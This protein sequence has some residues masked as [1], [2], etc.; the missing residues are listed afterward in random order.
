VKLRAGIVVAGVA[1]AALLTPAFGAGANRAPTLRNAPGTGFPDRD[2]F[3]QFPSKVQLTPGTVSVT[4]NGEPVIGLS[5]EAPGGT[6]SGAILLVDAS[7]SMTGKPIKGAMAAGRAFMVERNADLPVAVVAFNPAINVLADFSTDKHTLAVAVGKAPPLSYETH[8]YDA[9]EKAA[10]MAKH[11]GLERT[12][13]V[14]LSDGQELGSNASYDEA[15]QAVKEANIRVISIGLSSRFYNSSTL[16]RIAAD[17]GGTYIEVKKASQ[18]VPLY[19]SLSSQISNLYVVTYRSLLAPQV[20]ANVKVA[21]K[22]F[23]PATAHYTTPKLNV[24]PSGTFNRT[25]LD[26]VIES[27]YLMVF[28]IVAVLALLAFAIVSALDVRSRSMKRRMAH[29]VNI[30]TEEEGRLRREEVAAM[31]AERAERKFKSY[32]WWQNFERDVEIAGFQASPITMLGWAL[33]AG[34]LTSIVFAIL[35]QSLWGLLVGLVAPGVMR[36][37]VSLRLS[38]KRAEFAEQL[39][40][41]VDVL[42]GA[43][44]AGHSLVG[45]MNVMVDGAAEPSRDE[46]RR[47]MQDEQLGVPIDEALMVMSERMANEDLEQV[48]LVTRLSREAGGNTAEV[49][50]R[51]VDNIR[52]KMELRRLVKVLTAQGRM[53]RWILT[54]L[55]VALAGWI[56]VINPDWLDPLFDTTLGNVSLVLWVVLL[57]VGS[58]ILKKITDIVV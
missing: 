17:T 38:R 21:A 39:P 32:K 43:L 10:Q 54:V 19:S 8:T 11:Q 51:V 56:L 42:A 35:L 40:D 37:V 6:A 3:L 44:R 9:L 27:P 23:P 7:K 57:L 49:L 18:L 5:I 14:L 41:N 1:L 31:L 28:V 15:L 12:T 55:P 48:A 58:F 34:I 13:V 52:G 33:I 20:K 26:K 22:G 16:K 30:P 46:F 29:Y 45:A 36:F 2:Y 53:A 47:V 4:E 24:T 25:W 50:D